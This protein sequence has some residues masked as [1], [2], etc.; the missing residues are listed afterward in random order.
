MT[1]MVWDILIS[2][3]VGVLAGLG[4]GSGGILIVYLTAVDGMPQLFAQGLNLFTFVFALAAALIVHLHRHTLPVLVLF[5]TLIF[6]VTGALCGGLLAHMMQA[7]L[8]RLLLGILLLFMGALAL[9]KK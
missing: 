1:M 2:L 9:F 3:I 5:L 6:G 8:L 7:E 4:V